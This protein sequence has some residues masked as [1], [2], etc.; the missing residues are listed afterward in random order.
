MQHVIH[1]IRTAHPSWLGTRDTDKLIS[2]IFYNLT[3]IKGAS[4]KL[5]A[6][7]DTRIQEHTYDVRRAWKRPHD[8]P[9]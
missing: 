2:D 3:D 4:Q 9:S 5:L 8:C 1:I 6:A 7:L